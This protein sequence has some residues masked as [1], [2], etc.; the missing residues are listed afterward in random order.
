MIKNV[1]NILASF[2]FVFVLFSCVN[3][4]K[5]KYEQVVK[6]SVTQNDVNESLEELNRKF[7]IQEAELI[8]NY[9]E[10]NKTNFNVLPKNRIVI[11]DIKWT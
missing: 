6:H 5:P 10:N 11:T 9:V 7:L 8:K 1:L 2:I 4:D 3:N